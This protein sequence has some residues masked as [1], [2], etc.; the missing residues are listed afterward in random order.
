[1]HNNKGFSL[2]ISQLQATLSDRKD[3]REFLLSEFNAFQQEFKII[4]G[5]LLVK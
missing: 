5:S 4:S 2:E 1:M 3:E